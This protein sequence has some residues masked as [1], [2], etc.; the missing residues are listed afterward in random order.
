MA[1]PSRVARRAANH[2]ASLAIV[3][4][5]IGVAAIPVVVYLSQRSQR[6]GLLDAAWAIPVAFCSGAGALLF[7]RGARG[8]IAW[9]LERSG[10]RMRIRTARLL[11]VLAI[12]IA[13]S[14]AIAVGFYELLLRLEG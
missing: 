5:A 11:G 2:R 14:A 13:L 9:S 4:G 12:C 10:G 8:K 3:L 7:A 1:T 6:I